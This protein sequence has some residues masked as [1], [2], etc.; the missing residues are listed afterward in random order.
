LRRVSESG[1][2]AL[3]YFLLV[4]VVLFLD[5]K[6]HYQTSAQLI[7]EKIAELSRTADPIAAIGQ[8]LDFYFAEV[9]ASSGSYFFV[10]VL[11]L[12]LFILLFA[13]AINLSSSFQRVAFRP[14]FVIL[15]SATRRSFEQQKRNRDL[16]I[17]AI[18]VAFIINILAALA[19]NPVAPHIFSLFEKVVGLLS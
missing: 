6:R 7:K 16:W 17:G 19:L 14:P 15:N 18:L 9:A 8:K 10:I 11:E 13:A 4:F 3:V 2:S 1:Y 5:W 12:A